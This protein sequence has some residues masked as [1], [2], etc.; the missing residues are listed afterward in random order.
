MKA[1]RFVIL[2]SML[3]TAASKKHLTL[4]ARDPNY[5]LTYEYNLF[6]VRL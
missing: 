4:S 6:F 1:V 3:D 2:Q 5:L